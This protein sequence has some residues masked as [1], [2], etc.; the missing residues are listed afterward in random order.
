MYPFAASEPSGFEA[1]L[2]NNLAPEE[3]SGE[4]T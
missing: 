3:Y 4:E 1:I 2:F